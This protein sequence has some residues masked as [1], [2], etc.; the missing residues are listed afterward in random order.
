MFG[1][2]T[3]KRCPVCD[4][5]PHNCLCRQTLTKPTKRCAIRT[6]GPAEDSNERG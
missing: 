2:T 5:R 6:P 4:S 3:Y 1:P